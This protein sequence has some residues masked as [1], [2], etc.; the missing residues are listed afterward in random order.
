M[1]DAVVLKACNATSLAD[2]MI[3]D[4]KERQKHHKAARDVLVLHTNA[5]I[6]KH[7][8][9]PRPPTAR[10]RAMRIPKRVPML[11]RLGQGA[12]MHIAHPALRTVLQALMGVLLSVHK[13]PR[14]DFCGRWNGH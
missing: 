10:L 12:T 11:A 5:T 7:L 8:C 9:M 3:A 6:P 1:A 2:Q 4:E 14:R 13:D